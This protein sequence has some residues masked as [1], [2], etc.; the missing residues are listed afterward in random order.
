MDEVP[1]SM[2]LKDAAKTLQLS[3]YIVIFQ[4]NLV[5]SKAA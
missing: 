5:R 1:N 2:L 3:E 4:L